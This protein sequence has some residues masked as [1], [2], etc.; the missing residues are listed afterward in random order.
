M[1]YEDEREKHQIRLKSNF[2]SLLEK[3]SREIEGD[4]VNLDVMQVVKCRGYISSRATREFGCAPFLSEK[5]SG[6]AD[7]NYFNTEPP[8]ADVHEGCEHSDVFEK[9]SEDSLDQERY[10]QIVISRLRDAGCQLTERLSKQLVVGA[11]NIPGDGNYGLDDNESDKKEKSSVL[12]DSPKELQSGPETVACTKHDCTD[13]LLLNVEADAAANRAAQA[14]ADPQCRQQQLC[15]SPFLVVSTK[16]GKESVARSCSVPLAPCS[17]SSS[18]A[19]STGLNK[20]VVMHRHS[21]CASTIHNSAV[22]ISTISNKSSPCEPSTPVIKSAHSAVSYARLH[23]L[24]SSTVSS[25]VTPGF[26]EDSRGQQHVSQS[27]PPSVLLPCP[28]SLPP[29]SSLPSSLSSVAELEDLQTDSRVPADCDS[30]SQDSSVSVS[31]TPGNSSSCQQSA[32]AITPAG[33]LSNFESVYSPLS[34]ISTH[35]TPSVA[36][37]SLEPASLNRQRQPRAP[38]RSYRS[39]KYGLKS[40]MSKSEQLAI[41]IRDAREERMRQGYDVTPLLNMSINEK[42]NF[43][44]KQRAGISRRGC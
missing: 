38:L 28:E 4:V 9:E 35:S 5:E 33:P 30:L 17:P 26:S 15:S 3:Y 2:D 29:Q 23:S 16:T 21:Q 34:A 18:F 42:L 7:D 39:Q 31:L 41:M 13:I 25:P 22:D 44:W 1:T 20:E 19:E 14:R 37:N 32:P 12:V 8:L 40:G 10:T 6:I 36:E 11:R 27:H 24:R 43:V